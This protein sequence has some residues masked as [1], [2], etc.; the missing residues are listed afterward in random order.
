[1]GYFY[2][3]KQLKVSQKYKSIPI[4]QTRN[5]GNLDLNELKSHMQ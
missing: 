1:M 3:K 4:E 5:L 2:T